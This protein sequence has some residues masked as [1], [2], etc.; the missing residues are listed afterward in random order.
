MRIMQLAAAA[1]LVLSGVSAAQ[2]G[3]YEYPRQISV[4]GYG[5]ASAEPDMANIAFGVDIT[6]YSAVEAVEEASERM[7]G[8]IAAAGRFGVD[9]EDISTTSYSIWTEYEYDDYNYVYTDVLLYHVSDY[10]NLELHDP[11]RVGQVIAAV[12]EGGAN[13]ISSVYFTLEDRSGLYREA[14]S[15]AVADARERAEQLALE[16]GVA[17]GEPTMISEYSYD[18]YDPYYGYDYGYMSASMSMGEG[19][20]GMAAPSIMPSSLTVQTS[21]TISWEID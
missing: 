7:R 11:D 4:T 21:V 20:G 12:V 5:T 8:A 18:Y 13:Y 1:V 3:G 19:G 14:R 17:L 9:E 15:R 2:D 6:A 10:A 16:T